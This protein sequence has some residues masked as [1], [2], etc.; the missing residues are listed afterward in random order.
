V[1]GR[2]FSR[3]GLCLCGL[4]VAVHYDRQNRR[5]SCEE[6][7]RL[8]GFLAEPLAPPALPGI[9]DEGALQ[10]DR[11][12]VRSSNIR[13]LGWA[14]VTRPAGVETAP[15]AITP[16]PA[17]HSAEERE[18]AP[19]G[20]GDRVIFGLLDVEFLNGSLYR[21]DHVPAS[22]YLAILGA[23]SPGAAFAACLKAGGYSFLQLRPA[24]VRR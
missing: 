24:H 2:S 19:A 11:Q 6:T 4:A 3:D 5:R 7:R 15:G 18:T 12:E 16:G 17:S 22:V 1:P 14:P 10:I 21:Y 20:H 23:P 9:P 8:A 13:S